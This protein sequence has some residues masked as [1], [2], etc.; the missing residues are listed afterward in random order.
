MNIK[1]TSLEDAKEAIA[2]AQ[3]SSSRVLRYGRQHCQS[4]TEEL[5]EN[6]QGLARRRCLSLLCRAHI[7]TSLC[8]IRNTFFEEVGLALERDHVHEVELKVQAQCRQPMDF[9]YQRQIT[10][11]VRDFIVLLIA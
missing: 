7:D 4:T 9:I 5:H 6:L 1:F 11:W 2:W 10:Y 3:K 8:V